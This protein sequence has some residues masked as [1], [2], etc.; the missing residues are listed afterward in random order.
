M[1]VMP[2]PVLPRTVKPDRKYA[3]DGPNNNAIIKIKKERE[4][5]IMNEGKMKHVD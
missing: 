2:S 4:R 3:F 5:Q 1:I